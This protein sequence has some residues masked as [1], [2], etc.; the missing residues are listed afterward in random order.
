MKRPQLAAC[1]AY[2]REGD[3]LHVHSMDRLARNLDDLR[4]LVRDL[5]ARG[6]VV[7]FEKEG[8]TFTGEASPMA[9]LLLSMLGAVAEF[10]RALI[11]ER[12]AEGIAVAK[13]RGA[14]TGRP[15]SL[16][17]DQVAELR[18]QAAAGTAKAELARAFG[19]SRETVYAYLRGPQNV[20]KGLR[21][22]RSTVAEGHV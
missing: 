15:P 17:P 21:V 18:R 22:R 19:I 1:L 11:R 9:N 20:S 12:Q 10:E 8:L 16:S 6:V 14:Y 7:Q 5:T 2:L 4:G 13:A 3:T